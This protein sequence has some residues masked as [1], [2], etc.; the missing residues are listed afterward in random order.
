MKQICLT[1]FADE[2]SADFSIQLSTMKSLGFTHTEVRGVDGKGMDTYSV[3]E[4]RL[5]KKRLD[6]MGMKVSSLAS[7]IGKYDIDQPFAIH[8]E[9]MKHVVEL[10]HILETPYIR[11]FSFFMPKHQDPNVWTD[12]VLKRMDAI[13]SYEGL[14]GITLLHENEKGIY[15]DTAARCKL[16][17]DSFA[18]KPLRMAFDFANFIQC[19]EDTLPAYE[20][21]KEYIGYVHIKDAKADTGVIVPAGTGDGQIEEILRR[22]QVQGYRGFLSLEP[23]LTEFEG[24]KGLERDG[25][26]LKGMTSL[27]GADAFSLALTSLKSVLARIS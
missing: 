21:L 19:G 25:Q 23:H 17:M 1:G 15:G 8:F 16:L 10:A 22:L 7:P 13:V 27:S 18:G 5:I 14:A 26:S 11:M 6:D 9:H 3:S 2:I 4:A 24:L 20:L 12:E